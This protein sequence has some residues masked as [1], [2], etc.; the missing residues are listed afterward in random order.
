MAT[1]KIKEVNK[2]VIVLT[3]YNGCGKSYSAKLVKKDLDIG[4]NLNRYDFV[5]RQLMYLSDINPIYT[6]YSQFNLDILDYHVISSPATKDI[7]DYAKDTFRLEKGMTRDNVAYILQ[8]IFKC[9][10]V[11]IELLDTP[12]MNDY[13]TKFNLLYA[14]RKNA[15][16]PLIFRL[17]VD[18]YD[19]LLSQYYD[20][21]SKVDTFKYLDIV[22]EPYKTVQEVNYHR[23]LY[24]A[25]TVNEVLYFKEKYNAP[26]IQIDMDHKIRTNCLAAA[27]EIDKLDLVYNENYQK[28]M[29]EIKNLSTATVKNNLDFDTAIGNKIKYVINFD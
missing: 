29:A 28:E 3:G 17:T 15:D 27:G 18:F 21:S 12:A 11:N 4:V 25:Y 14:N 23:I 8:N 7:I 13:Y 19:L 1:V 16:M 24:Y 6:S 2:P 26:V 10:N 20:F 5:T 9:N 22:I